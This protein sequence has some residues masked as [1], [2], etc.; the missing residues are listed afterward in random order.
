MEENKR[1]Q[2]RRDKETLKK[3]KKW[4]ENQ[5]LEI[6]ENYFGNWEE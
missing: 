5:K 3:K 2:N 6:E 1:D 4:N